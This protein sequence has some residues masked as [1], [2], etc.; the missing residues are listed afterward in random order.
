VIGASGKLTGF[1]GGLEAKERLLTLEGGDW[2]QI[3]KTGDLF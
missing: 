2:S 3:G 1:A